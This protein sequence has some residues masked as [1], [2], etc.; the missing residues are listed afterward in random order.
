MKKKIDKKA[1]VQAP[2]LHVGN[3]MDKASCDNMAKAIGTVLKACSD[4]RSSDDVSVKALQVL[5][6]MAEV[7]NI[8]VNSC[9]FGV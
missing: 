1:K 3:L 8:N 9:I 2:A 7:K 4:T 5:T 6:D